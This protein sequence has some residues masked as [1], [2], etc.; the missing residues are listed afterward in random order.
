MKLL[1]NK[2]YEEIVDQAKRYRNLKE[3]IMWMGEF[4]DYRVISDFLNSKEADNSIWNH[5]ELR[6]KIRKIRRSTSTAFSK[7]TDYIEVDLQ[8]AI[9]DY[10]ESIGFAFTPY[11]PYDSQPCLFD[12]MAK[13]TVTNISCTCHKCSPR[14]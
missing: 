5:G 4:E 1:K 14:C 2:E 10:V 8:K 3:F 7:Y 11:T 6:E 13:N 12:D 9:D